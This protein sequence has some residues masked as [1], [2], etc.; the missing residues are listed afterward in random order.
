MT[1]IHGRGAPRYADHEAV[2]N[3]WGEGLS[4]EEIARKLGLLAGHSVRTI[5]MRARNRGDERAK[6]RREGRTGHHMIPKW[7]AALRAEAA[8][9]DTTERRL[10][11]DLLSAIVDDNLFAALLED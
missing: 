7:R 2:I 10:I 5:V 8:R 1:D 6:G 4:S 9:R 3:L 11:N